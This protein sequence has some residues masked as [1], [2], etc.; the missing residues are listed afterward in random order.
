MEKAG[1]LEVVRADKTRI[2][3]EGPEVSAQPTARPMTPEERRELG[4]E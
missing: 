1:D 4:I 3:I 2:V